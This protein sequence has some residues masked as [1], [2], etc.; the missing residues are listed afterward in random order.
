LYD[1]SD[2][3]SFHDVKEWLEELKNNVGDDT[4]IYV[5]GSKAD[6]NAKRAVL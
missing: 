5:V 6:R 3:E 2:R 4:V 1:I